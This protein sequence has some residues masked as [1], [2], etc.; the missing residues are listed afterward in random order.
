MLSRLQALYMEYTVFSTD[1]GWVAVLAS[2]KG[3]VGTSLPWSTA[4]GALGEIGAGVKE[5]VNSPERFED[6]TKRLRAYFA[7]Q[8]VSFPDGFDLAAA[9]PFQKRVWQTARL[10]PYGET[11]SY[12][13]LA[14]GAGRPGAARAVGQAMAK[15]RLPII[16]PCHRVIG[17]DGSLGGFAGGVDIKKRLLQLEASVPVSISQ[18]AE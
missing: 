12:G 6:L 7:G 11:R 14:Q 13:W 2:E 17:S 4:E 18:P 3:L 10:I 5:A 16:V 8:K 15:N 1:M 9:T